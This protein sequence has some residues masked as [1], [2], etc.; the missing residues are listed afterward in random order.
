MRREYNPRLSNQV[1]RQL[2]RRYHVVAFQKRVFVLAAIAVASLLI[3]LG[4]SIRIFAGNSTASEEPLQKYYTSIQIHDGDTLWNIADEYMSG[5]NL[6]K[7]EYIEELRRLNH[8]QN[9]TIYNGEY[10]IVSYY[11]K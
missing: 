9:D 5:S 11:A 7:K 6:T 10:I 2:N 3:L 8:L 1:N 4:T